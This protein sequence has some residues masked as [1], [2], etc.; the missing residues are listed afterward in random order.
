MSPLPHFNILLS[1]AGLRGIPQ[2][3]Y[4][5]QSQE[6]ARRARQRF[7]LPWQAEGQGAESCVAVPHKPGL[8]FS[9]WSHLA[10]HLALLGLR[11]ASDVGSLSLPEAGASIWD[12]SSVM[13]TTH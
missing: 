11:L 6:V 1:D 3:I 9:I 10:S 4:E 2:L 8:P 7:S 13:F 5:G 12:M